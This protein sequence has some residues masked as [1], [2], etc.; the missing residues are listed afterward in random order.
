MKYILLILVITFL[1]CSKGS[2][3]PNNIPPELIGKWKVVE[4]YTT[5]GGS[6]P[7]WSLYDSGRIYDKWFKG[8]GTY[9]LTRPS[10]NPD[11]MGGNYSVLENNITYSNNPCTTGAPV[12]I[13]LLTENE[14][15]ID[16][17]FFEPFKVKYIKVIE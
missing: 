4:R 10:T 16:T 5:D 3:E 8:D 13:E 12:T 7:T 6:D 9:I 14:L 15:I 11:C 17:N 2:E 1:G